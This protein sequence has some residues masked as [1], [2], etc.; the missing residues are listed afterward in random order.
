[1]TRVAAMVALA[2][3][4]ALLVG[5]VVQMVWPGARIWP[6]PGRGSWQLFLVWGL[7]GFGTIAG[8]VLGILDWNSLGWPVI[9]RLPIGSLLTLAGLGL[10]F[11]A[12]ARL[13][14]AQ[15]SGLSGGLAIDGLY[16]WSRNPQ[17]VGDIIATSGWIVLTGSRLFL[18]IGCIAIA[19]YLFLPRLEEPWL[20]GR[21]GEAYRAYRERVPRFI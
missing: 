2:A 17:Y 19:W 10:A 18:P 7:F 13:G 15:T 4:A 21:F 8:I 20:E 12:I 14:V 16:G 1:M 3:H 9:L 6:P 11:T 5:T